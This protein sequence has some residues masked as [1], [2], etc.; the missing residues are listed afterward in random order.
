MRAIFCL[1][2]RGANDD[3]RRTLIV[4]SKKWFDTFVVDFVKGQD[5]NQQQMLLQGMQGVWFGGRQQRPQ[6]PRDALL[7]GVAKIVAAT[8]PKEKAAAYEVECRQ[9][10]EFERQAAVANLVDRIDEK[11]KLSPEQ[12][13]KV[14]AA[15]NDHWDEKEAPQL[16]A[17]VVGN[18]WPGIPEVTVGWVFPD[19]SPAQQAVLRRTN[20]TGTTH[21]FFGGGVLG[22][23]VGGVNEVIDDIDLE[24]NDAAEH[25]N[26]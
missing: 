18:M 1:P 24:T 14:T 4:K 23:L 2:R 25:V 17:F 9:R 5:P 3:E 15:L 19:L 22:G 21:V 13:K 6:N 20:S 26:R 12:W 8:L 7:R 16:E 11:V 10:K